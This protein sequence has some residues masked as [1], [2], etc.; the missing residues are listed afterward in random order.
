VIVANG[1]CTEPS[2]IVSLPVV[3]T[4]VSFMAIPP[5]RHPTHLIW[6]D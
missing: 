2:P 6:A 4:N 5:T 1:R 3:L